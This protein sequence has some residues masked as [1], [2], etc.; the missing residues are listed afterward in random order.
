IPLLRESY[1]EKY[2]YSSLIVASHSLDKARGV[3][4]VAYHIMLVEASNPIKPEPFRNG[5]TDPTRQINIPRFASDAIDAD[6]V[7]EARRLVERTYSTE[8]SLGAK[9]LQA[10]YASSEVI[11]DTLK[12]DE[13]EVA[14]AL[15]VNGLMAVMTQLSTLTKKIPFN[16]AKTEKTSFVMEHIFRD[17][18][19]TDLNGS[20]IRS[21]VIIK[22]VAR[23]NNKGNGFA[24]NG[25]SGG[26]PLSLFSMYIDT[27]FKGRK[28]QSLFGKK[29]EAKPCFVPRAVITNNISYR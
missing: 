5:N 12:V 21:D 19:V 28:T 17:G 1:G 23:T 14:G 26:V 20:Q 9:H 27:V 24:L 18:S 3:L 15:A 29:E 22:T 8:T 13:P 25:G 11:P 10:I 7:A 2:R 6:Y 4:S 16:L